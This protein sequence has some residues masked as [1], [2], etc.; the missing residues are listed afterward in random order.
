MSRPRIALDLDEVVFDWLE[1][2]IRTFEEEDGDPDAFPV[3]FDVAS[4]R[5]ARQDRYDWMEHVVGQANWRWF[6]EVPAGEASWWR[7]VPLRVGEA[8]AAATLAHRYD[9]VIL[10]SRPR[11]A[12]VPTLEWMADQEAPF[13]GLFVVEQAGDKVG[14]A[15]GLA[16]DTLVDDRASVIAD[17]ILHNRTSFFPIG[18]VVYSQPWNQVIPRSRGGDYRRISS[19][20]EL[21][22]Q[23]SPR[24]TK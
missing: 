21:V 24:R 5:A 9:V 1:A 20:E 4:L 13:Q 18:P 23:M 12:R 16:C 22:V 6:W 10:T 15:A 14:A 3:P 19:L 2:F 8:E 11:V 7:A 17:A